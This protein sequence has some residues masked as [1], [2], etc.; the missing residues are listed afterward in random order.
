MGVLAKP[1]ISRHGFTMPL[2]SLFNLSRHD[3]PYRLLKK[4]NVY[5]ACFEPLAEAV[6]FY[7]YEKGIYKSPAV[8]DGKRVRDIEGS[9]MMG[10]NLNYY[11]HEDFTEFDSMDDKKRVKWLNSIQLDEQLSSI[12]QYIKPDDNRILGN[13][14]G[15]KKS[16]GH[17]D[18]ERY[19]YL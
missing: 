3:T 6:N 18:F 2:M 12:R 19:N 11:D 14:F 7:D 13:S 4:Y 10:G 17:T 1:R 16:I 9:W 5:A 15:S 8:I